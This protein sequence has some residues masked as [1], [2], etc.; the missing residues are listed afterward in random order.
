MYNEEG[1]K[2][3]YLRQYLEKKGLELIECNDTEVRMFGGNLLGIG[4]H[5]LVSYEWNE[6]LMKL[7][8]DKGFDVIGIPRTQLSARAVGPTV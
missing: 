7:L 2:V 4:N 8:D 3:T 1:V 5:K 6:R